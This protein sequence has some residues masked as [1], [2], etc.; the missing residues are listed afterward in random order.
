MPRA[1]CRPSSSSFPLTHP[2]LPTHHPLPPPPPHAQRFTAHD[3]AVAKFIGS[4][5]GEIAPV[6]E[7]T[8]DD[9]KKPAEGAV[10]GAAAA[11]KPD[12]AKKKNS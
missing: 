10:A 5:K 7:A 4:K 11:A 3:F 12:A 9:K 1:A 6:K 2:L 8:K